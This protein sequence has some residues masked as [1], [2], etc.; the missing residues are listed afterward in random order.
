M[1]PGLLSVWQSLIFW[2]KIKFCGKKTSK[3]YSN[4]SFDMC[5]IRF[6]WFAMVFF[7]I[8]QKTTFLGKK[9]FSSYS[10][11]H[12]WHKVHCFHAGRH[13]W[14]LENDWVFEQNFFLSLPY[15]LCY[16]NW[17]SLSL[18]GFTVPEILKWVITTF[19]QFLRSVFFISNIVGSIF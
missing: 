18:Q 9:L 6:K 14:R 19:V 4:Q 11:K 17:Q 10:F 1:I 2:E 13:Q 5:F 12:S 3:I 16:F 8:L 15:H 7:I